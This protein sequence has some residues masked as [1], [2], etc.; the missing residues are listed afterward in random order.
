MKK[1]EDISN[2]EQF[3]TAQNIDQDDSIQKSILQSRL[4]SKNNESIKID[5]NPSAN[6][7]PSML[8]FIYDDLTQRMKNIEE[9]GSPLTQLSRILLS[10]LT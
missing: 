5:K 8:S 2:E 10:I 4:E 1:N 3:K 7:D 9:F 6:K